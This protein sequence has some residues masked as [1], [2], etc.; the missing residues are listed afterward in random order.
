VVS[1]AIRTRRND[2]APNSAN[3]PIAV[4][5]HRLSAATETGAFPTH[6]STATAEIVPATAAAHATTSS[7]NT[8]ISPRGSRIMYWKSGP[9]IPPFSHTVVPSNQHEPTLVSGSSTP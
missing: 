7:W 6:D 5:V 2:S 4:S 9:A 1:S 3:T 8:T